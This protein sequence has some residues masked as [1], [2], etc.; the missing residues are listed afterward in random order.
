MDAG[1]LAGMTPFILSA[2]IRG[3]EAASL[4]IRVSWHDDSR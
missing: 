2:S 4:F 3:G 1:S